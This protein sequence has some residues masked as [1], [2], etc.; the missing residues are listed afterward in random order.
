[1]PGFSRASGFTPEA[2]K[3]R[4]WCQ[5]PVALGRPR[6]LQRGG[7]IRGQ[8]RADVHL[9]PR[10][11]MGEPKPP[12]V[13]E[14]PLQA[15]VAGHPVDGVAADRKVDRLQVDADL[16]R[17]ACLEPDVE[18]RMSCA[19]FSPTTATPASA[20]TPISS[21]VTYFVAATTVMPGPASACSAS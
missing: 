20:S 14:L 8:I 9:R 17:A 18:Q 10:Q 2:T 13:Q 5:A 3:A 12:R 6:Q 4:A 1:M 7:Q 19:R 21:A 15:E 11:R 16:V